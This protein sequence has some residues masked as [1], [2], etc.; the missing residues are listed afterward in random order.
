MAS[1][2]SHVG[3]HDHGFNNSPPTATWLPPPA[4]GQAARQPGR[5][6]AKWPSRPPAPSRPRAGPRPRPSRA[7]ASRRLHLLVQRPAFAFRRHDPLD[8]HPRWSPTSS[9]TPHGRERQAHPS[10]TAPARR[11][12]HREASPSST[13]RAAT[14]TT[15]RGRVAHESVFNRNDGRFRCPNSQQ[16]YSPFTTWTRGLAWIIS[17]TPNSSSS[18]KPCPT[19]TSRRSAAGAQVGPPPQTARATCDYYLDRLLRAR[20]HPVLGLRRAEPAPLGDYTR[21]RRSSTTTNRSTAPPPPSAC[22]A[23]CASAVTS[24]RRKGPRAALLPGRSHHAA[25]SSRALPRHR[26]RA[27]RPPA[28]HRL[29]PPQRLGLHP[30]RPKVP[31]GEACMWGDYHIR[32]AALTLQRIIKGEKD[33]TFFG[34]LK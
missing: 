6:S 12:D 8:A 24:A 17:A 25:R 19:P 34:C 26:P 30:A 31:C 3:V 2:V 22:R 32:E 29:P 10:S 7:P 11:T 1:H 9:A 23:C 13:A 16:G 4:R 20:R 15:C 14:A 5:T 33:Y 18:S 21:G 28:A 27:P